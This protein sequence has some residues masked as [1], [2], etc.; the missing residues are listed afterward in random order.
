MAL[1]RRKIASC[2]Q[3]ELPRYGIDNPDAHRCAGIIWNDVVAHVKAT[4]KEWK[5]EAKKAEAERLADMSEAPMTQEE[6]EAY[7][8]KILD[9][10]LR[11]NEM[12]IAELD[13]FKAELGLEAKGRDIKIE[14]VDFSKVYPADADVYAV[15]AE[16]IRKGIE[17][18]NEELHNQDLD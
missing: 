9:G 8:A 3:R 1:D 17:E 16:V 11:N 5:A 18:A 13:R 14:M 6:R 7:A 2:L 4:K 15:T 12:S 10:A